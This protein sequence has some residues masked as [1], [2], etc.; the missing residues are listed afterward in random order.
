MTDGYQ[1]FY[2]KWDN[3]FSHSEFLEKEFPYKLSLGLDQYGEPLL[4]FRDCSTSGD[5][6]LVTKLYDDMFHHLVRL[7]NNSR[8]HGAV[9]TGQPGIGGSL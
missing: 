3:E 7:R 4:P 6:I 1:Q 2:E 8:G 9:I 5:E